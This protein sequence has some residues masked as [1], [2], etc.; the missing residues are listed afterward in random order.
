MTTTPSPELTGT[1]TAVVSTRY[2]GD[3]D[4]Q[5]LVTGAEAD[6]LGCTAP[7]HASPP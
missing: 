7:P 3:R 2:A 6:A 5:Q 1:R 4:R